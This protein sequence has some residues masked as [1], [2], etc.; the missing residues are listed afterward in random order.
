MTT[1]ASISSGP[2]AVPQALAN[3][4]ALAASTCWLAYRENRP[5]LGVPQTAAKLTNEEARAWI[6]KFQSGYLKEVD[7]R[8]NARIW[9][10]QSIPFTS[11]PLQYQRALASRFLAWRE[12]ILA[13]NPD[14]AWDEERGYYWKAGEGEGKKIDQSSRAVIWRGKQAEWGLTAGDGIVWPRTPL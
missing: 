5:W 7:R 4:M 13:E 12:E 14:L 3:E 2:P 8:R 10:S 1:A 11:M 6:A 9:R